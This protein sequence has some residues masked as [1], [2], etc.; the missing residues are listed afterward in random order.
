MRKYNFN[1]EVFV[2]VVL[3][4]VEYTKAPN[5]S[6][7]LVRGRRGTR[8]TLCTLFLLLS[9]VSRAVHKGLEYSRNPDGCPLPANPF[10]ACYA[11][12]AQ[13]RKEANNVFFFQPLRYICLR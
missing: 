6:D 3:M 1:A 13:Q 2:Y 5:I 8:K 12:V 7:V 9:S 10:V 11:H 4:H